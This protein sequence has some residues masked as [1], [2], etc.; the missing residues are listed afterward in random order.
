M[1]ATKVGLNDSFLL[2]EYWIQENG[3]H[4]CCPDHNR[5]FVSEANESLISSTMFSGYAHLILWSHANAN[6]SSVSHVPALSTAAKCTESSNSVPT[7][8]CPVTKLL[9][10]DWTQDLL[11]ELGIHQGSA[12]S[13]Q[14]SLS[15]SSMCSRRRRC[16]CI[17]LWLLRASSK[18][19]HGAVDDQC[20]S[21]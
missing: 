4:G 9:S 2:Y 11:L 1:L 7:S 10:Q 21:S 16:W 19:F 13:T 15:V 12:C 3:S 14:L 20:P 5:Y 17:C 18:D 8:L 6:L